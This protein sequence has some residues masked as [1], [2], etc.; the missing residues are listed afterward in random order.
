MEAATFSASSL[1]RLPGVGF[2][3]SALSLAG[4]FHVL[5]ELPI[6]APQ[7]ARGVVAV[8]GARSQLG[9]NGVSGIPQQP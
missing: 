7:P 2:L 6:P 8:V 1:A 3:R 4:P 5:R 9:V